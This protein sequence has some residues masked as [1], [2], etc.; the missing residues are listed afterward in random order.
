MCYDQICFWKRILRLWEMDEGRMLSE[1]EEGS[2][3]SGERGW[4]LG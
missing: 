3:K 2:G 4:W 1:E